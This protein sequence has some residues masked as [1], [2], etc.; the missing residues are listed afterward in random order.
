MKKVLVCTLVFDRAE[1]PEDAATGIDYLVEFIGVEDIPSALA[2]Y[3][4]IM[5]KY[6]GPANGILVERGMLHFE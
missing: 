4:E 5:T 1:L 2:K 3:R 6:A